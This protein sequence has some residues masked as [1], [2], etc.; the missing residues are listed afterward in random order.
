[1]YTHTR[2]VELSLR[3]TWEKRNDPRGDDVGFFRCFEI[4]IL[5]SFALTREVLD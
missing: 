2:V 5:S 1:M 4:S 3:L